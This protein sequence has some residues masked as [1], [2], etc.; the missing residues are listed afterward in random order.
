MKYCAAAVIFVHKV[1][2]RLSASR[3][4]TGSRG[5]CGVKWLLYLLHHLYR[6]R[7][8]SGERQ[9]RSP[10]WKC[11]LGQLATTEHNSDKRQADNGGE[12]VSDQDKWGRGKNEQDIKRWKRRR[13]KSEL[14]R[15]WLRRVW[16][17]ARLQ[18]ARFKHLKVWSIH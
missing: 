16:C 7:S 11:R 1:Q 9:R 15:Y 5:L 14:T 18:L 10:R 2:C 13:K 3:K 6:R 17:H 12:T 8:W 4:Q